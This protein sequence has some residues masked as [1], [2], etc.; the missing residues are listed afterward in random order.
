[1]PIEPEEFQERLKTKVRAHYA[2]SPSPLLLS[3]L[4]SDIEKNGTWWPNDKGQ[5]SLKQLII[6]TCAR[7][8][9]CLGQEIACLR[10]GGNAGS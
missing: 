10:R 9:N 1:M 6:E 8:G 3:H 7:S 2:A 4:G 5:R